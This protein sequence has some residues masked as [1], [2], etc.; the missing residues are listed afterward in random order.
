[1]KTYHVK[2]AVQ[3]LEIYEIEADDPE[4][5]SDDWS[6]GDLIYTDDDALDSTVL[7]VQEVQP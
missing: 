5:A 4:T 6:S 7:S 1:M 3:I 2:V